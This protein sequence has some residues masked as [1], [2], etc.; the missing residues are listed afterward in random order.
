MRLC[1]TFDG[2]QK[3][4]KKITLIFSLCLLVQE[5]LRCVLLR[6]QICSKLIEQSKIVILHCN[7]HSLHCCSFY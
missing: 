7:N 3:S 2:R 4:V 5:G 1:E 6:I